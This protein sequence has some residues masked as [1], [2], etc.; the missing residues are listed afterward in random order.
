M[1]PGPRSSARWAHAL[2]RVQWGS[3]TRRQF[4]VRH[5]KANKGQPQ[6]SKALMLHFDHVLVARQLSI[7]EFNQSINQSINYTLFNYTLFPTR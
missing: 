7:Y 5:F 6:A 4:M 1:Q 3:Q 2:R